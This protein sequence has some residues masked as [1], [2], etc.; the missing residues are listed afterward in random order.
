ML[1]FSFLCTLRKEPP[2]PT[3]ALYMTKTGIINVLA[4]TR[5]ITKNLKGLIADTSMAS[6]CSVTFIDPSSAPNRELTL[7]AQINAVIDGANAL[8]IAIP[9]KEGSHDVAPK[10]A[11]DGRECLVKTM[12]VIKPVTVIKK[13][14]L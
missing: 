4:I 10:L 5:V 3:K 12:P 9:I 14:D 2:N 1:V 7:P 13:R 8:M 11:N 6:I